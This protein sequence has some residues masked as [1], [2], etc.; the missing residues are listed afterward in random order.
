MPPNN[1]HYVE[2]V[3]STNGG[4]REKAR[5]QKPCGMSDDANYIEIG[6][7][8]ASIRKGFSDLSQVDWARKHGFSVTRWNNWEKGVRRTPVDEAE[9]LSDLY[10]V[11]L[12]FIYRGRRSGLSENASKVL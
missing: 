11:D 4:L 3:N 2:V 1:P 5:G 12:D 7:R 6:Q 8:L 9:H 10:G